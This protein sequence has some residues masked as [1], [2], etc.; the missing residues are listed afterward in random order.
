MFTLKDRS[1]MEKA[2]ERARANHPRVKV[3]TLGSYLVRGS[4]GNFYTVTMSREGAL[5]AIDCGCVAGQFSTPCY[6][7]A[8]ALAVHMGLLRVRRASASIAAAV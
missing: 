3:Q 4:A 2:I 8:A 7:A 1:Q 5:K 6:H